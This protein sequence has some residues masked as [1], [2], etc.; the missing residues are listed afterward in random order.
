[1]STTDV[2]VD[3]IE[4]IKEFAAAGYGRKAISDYIGITEYAVKCVLE[5]KPR[6]PNES[7]STRQRQQLLNAAFGAPR[8]R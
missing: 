7:L 5:G 6:P 3:D 2:T 1:V 4:R 8:G